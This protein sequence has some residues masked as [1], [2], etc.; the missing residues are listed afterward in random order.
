MHDLTPVIV[1]V[2]QY[3][4]RDT[5]RPEQMLSPQDIAAA[6]AGRA[7]ADAGATAAL[8]AHVDTVA[9]VRLFEH[10][11]ADS[12]MWPN[13]FGCSNNLPWSV[14]RR[15]GITPRRAIYAEVGGHTP[16]RLINTLAAQIHAG[17]V[18]MA[19]LTGAEAIASIRDATRRGIALDWHEALDGAFENRW[20][21]AS[22]VSDYEQRHGIAWPIHVYAL[23]EQVR[24]HERELSLVECRAGIADLFAPFTET[25]AANPFAQFPSARSAEFLREVSAENY[26]LCEPYTKWMVAQDAVNQGAAVLLTSV[27]RARELGISSDRFVYLRGCGD[28]D[29]RFVLERPR[30]AASTAQGL[31]IQTAL[32][33]AELE[34]DKIGPI[35][36]YSCFPIA[37]TSACEHLG[38][39]PGS[40]RALTVTGGLPY[41]GGP[42]NNYSMH[43]IAS[44]VERIRQDRAA[45]GLVVA[46]GGYLS[47]HSVGIYSGSLSAPWRAQSS[48][49]AQQQ[50]KAGPRVTVSE[51]ASGQAR[52]ESYAAIYARGAPA[53]GFVVARCERDDTRCM[54][55]VREGDA[56]TLAALFENTV[57]GRRIALTEE[58]DMH[59]FTFAG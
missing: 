34:V 38:L 36:L 55:R 41:F 3:V 42:G 24:R 14:A 51:A 4:A 39:V 32:D 13:P 25:A 8:A 9:V 16:Q 15:L 2:G 11:V 53:N 45:H 27:G 17:E 22:F 5:S 44:M 46:N 56:A 31:A 23:F 43:A 19:L 50:A 52:I 18:N 28:V 49:S 35:D 30:L 10:S 47:K 7:L 21:G 6:A 1:G 12:A 54:A 40:G 37:V 59:Y 48:A 20:P 58:Q 29:E 57:I 33:G 26:L